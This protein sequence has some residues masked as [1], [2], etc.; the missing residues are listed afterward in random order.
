MKEKRRTH[1]SLRI[2]F[3]LLVIIEMVVIALISEIVTSLLGKY[4]DISIQI[5]G[6]VWAVLISVVLGSAVTTFLG[7]K[8]FDPIQKLG[9]AM[10]RVAD[11]N[12]EIRLDDK[13]GFREIQEIYNNFNLMTR[14]LQS[15]EILQTDFVSNV[16]HEFKTPINA[17]EGYATL[18]QDEE[19]PLTDE[20]SQYVGKILFN[21]KRLSKLVGNILLLSK[22]DNQTIQTKQVT[23]RIDEQIRQSVVLLE[24]EWTKKE[25]DFDVDLEVAEYTGN[26]NLMLH[27]WNNLL[28][29]AIKFSPQN[30]FIGIKLIKK[31][32]RII[33]TITDNGPGI[34]EDMQ[35]HIFDRFYQSDSS[36]KEEGNGLGLA[37]VKQIIEQSGGEVGVENKAGG[38]CQFTV[39]L[40]EPTH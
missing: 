36:H 2:R 12:F 40:F 7:K 32:G 13:C 21:T 34:P 26:E 10:S 4:F 29:N 33:Y 15:T 38:G 18:L 16:S 11:G 6:A 23:F 39:T 24:A 8:I 1:L 22:V 14:E 5:P 9:E 35:K 28:G 27:V 25:I 20:Q 31:D 19:N 17:I 30:G 37:L 3:T